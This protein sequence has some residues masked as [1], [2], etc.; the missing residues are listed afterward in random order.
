MYNHLDP[1]IY[2]QVHSALALRGLNSQTSLLVS[3]FPFKASF[4]QA[5][6]L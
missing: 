5:L 6:Q 2:T 1:K 3:Q 4:C